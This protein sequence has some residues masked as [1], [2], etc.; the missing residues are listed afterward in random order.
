MK[1]KLYP[2]LLKYY[3][4]IIKMLKKRQHHSILINSDKNLGINKLVLNIKKWIFCENIKKEFFCNKCIKCNLIEKKKFFDI[5]YLKLFKKIKINNLREIIKKILLTPQYSNKKVIYIEHSELLTE[6]E[7]N[8]LL[9]IIEEPPKN[10]IFFLQTNKIKNIISTLKSR[11]YIINIFNEKKKKNIKWLLKN[12]NFNYK[13]CKQA[14]EISNNI[15]LLA[16]K[17]LLGNSW[18]IRK[19][20]YKCLLKKIKKKKLIDLLNII[21]KE[22]IIFFLNLIYTIFLDSIKYKKKMFNFIINI[23]QKKL[24]IFISKKFKKKIIYKSIN[25]WMQFEKNILNIN[26]INYELVLLEQIFKWEKI[27]KNNVNNILLP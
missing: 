24:I 20:F 14:I 6:L 13:K 12:T 25:S 27:L 1:N 22:F 16:K 18:K 11:L 3:K 10:T 5:Y 8:T 19:Y 17:I 7:S 2:W 4:K 23:D 15:P 26:R 9:K 21:K